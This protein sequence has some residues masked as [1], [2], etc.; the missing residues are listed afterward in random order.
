MSHYHLSALLYLMGR[1][2]FKKGMAIMTDLIKE[3]M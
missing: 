1:A 3:V 2:L